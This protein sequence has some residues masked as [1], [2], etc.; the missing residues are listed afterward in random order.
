MSSH[1][2]KV[3]VSHRDEN[4]V[5]T[6]SGV[7]GYDDLIPRKSNPV[8]ELRVSEAV[9]SRSIA[10]VAPAAISCCYEERSIIVSALKLLSVGLIV[11][12]FFAVGIET[13]V[14]CASC[15]REFLL[16]RRWTIL[17]HVGYAS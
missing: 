7:L 5:R 3:L 9:L 14:V 16:C 15:G 6:R 10:S 17:L 2:R 12:T 13:S 8:C 11:A 4:I 1:L